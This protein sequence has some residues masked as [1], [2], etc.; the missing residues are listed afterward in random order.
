[1]LDKADTYIQKTHDMAAELA[2]DGPFQLRFQL[3]TRFSLAEYYRSKGMVEIAD[4]HIQKTG[5]V[6]EDAW[7][8]LG[9]FDNADGIG[10][11]SA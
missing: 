11:D 3:D 10:F 8:V 5:F 4:E 1:M 7:M 9:P 6:T 2:P